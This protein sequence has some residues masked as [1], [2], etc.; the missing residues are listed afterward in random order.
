[1]ADLTDLTG[2][3]NVKLSG[4]DSGGVEQ[5]YIGSTNRR[6]WVETSIN[7]STG[8]GNSAVDSFGRLRVS[9]PETVFESTFQY[10][11]QPLLFVE[12]TASGATVTQDSNKK[13]VILSATTTT[14]SRA[15]F[16]SR[17]YLKYH[18]GKSSL[19]MMSFNFKSAATNVDKLIGQFDDN[20]G[21][22]FK[23]SSSTL[24]VIQRSK[25]SG[26]VVDTAIAQSSWNLDKLDGT[27]T[28]GITLDLSKQQI[29]VIDQQWLGAGR[30]R[31]GFRIDGQTIYCHQILNANNL[32]TLY[33]QTADLPIRVEIKNNSATASTIEFT[34]STLMSEGG[35]QPEGLLRSINNG[36]TARTFAG[37]TS[38]PVLS[39]RKQSA[40]VNVPVQIVDFG[41]IATS[42]DDFLIQLILNGT[43]TGASFADVGGVCQA[44]VS[45][46]ALSGGTVL[47]STYL[48]GS[49]NGNSTATF[50]ALQNALNVILGASI[51]GTSDIL[52]IYAS[53]I[54][55]SANLVA[56]MN[57]KEFV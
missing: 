48:A 35:W 5:E 9:E 8:G 13:A 15:I 24:S 33:T 11:K 3:Q 52:S 56:Y 12:S 40:F 42:G 27:G 18:P 20:N 17:Y 34:C 10:D 28:S 23:L 25:T 51:A 1:M 43:L 46:T 7:S 57:Y 38:V 32:T 31:C 29:L 26:S 2:A 14:N 19:L 41:A 54:T 45:A 36:V 37:N 55:A 49:S 47:V 6:L 22:F 30:V 44:D 4:S 53:N 50:E 16:Q 21:V 39:L